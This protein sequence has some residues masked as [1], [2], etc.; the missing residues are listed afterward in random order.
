MRNNQPVSQVETVVPENTFIYSRT[1]LKGQIVE[2][3]QGFVELSGFTEA[4]LLG[5]PHNLV[6]HPDMPAEAFADLWQN[7][8]LGKPWKGLVKNRRK[9]GGFYWVVANVSPVREAGQAVGFQSIRS[10]ASREQIAAAESAYRKIRG[11]SKT[12]AIESGRIVTRH[13]SWVAKLMA[14]E[15]QIV[16]FVS[17][18]LLTALAGS[19]SAVYG[20]GG[21]ATGVLSAVLLIWAVLLALLYL[22]SALGQFR[23]INRYLEQLLTTGNLTDALELP[24]NDNIGKIASRI[25]LT[26]ASFR[27]TL[28]LI[29][30]AESRV[31]ATTD[32]LDGSMA[33]LTQSA[34]DLSANASSAAA[35]I[36]QMTVSIG[37]VAHSAELTNQAAGLA[38]DRV[39]EGNALAAGATEKIQDLFHTVARSVGTI[40]ALGQRSQ[41]IGV[42]AN[43][44][45]DIADQTNLLALNAAIEAARA[46][47][48]GRGFAVVADEVRKL[49]ERTSAATRQIEEMILQIQND[50]AGAVEG[51]RDSAAKVDQSVE[52]VQR[53]DHSL[54]AIKQQLDKTTGMIADI[55]HAVGQQNGAMTLMAKN[56]EQ[57]SAAMDDNLKVVGEIGS[58]S[59]KVIQL[60][61]RVEKAI[62]LYRI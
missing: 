4:E 41:E 56:V 20:I 55:S 1:D 11:G 35:G 50:T 34:E 14:F 17:F 28:Q 23:R 38:G 10:R 12:S 32:V 40:E 45:K 7:L 33:H 52:L 13:R 36:E 62:R 54:D 42:V 18:A 46:G 57:V 51:M 19:V 47:E 58:V 21:N 37:E 2:V 60:T 29:N 15:T 59:K 48:Q 53:A 6:R 8:K 49:A 25:D 24:R 44:I 39:H 31:T 61:Q 26:V 27:A 16:T 22:P 5:S 3:N 30:Y 9:D 43:V